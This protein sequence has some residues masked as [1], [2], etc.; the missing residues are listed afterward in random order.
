MALSAPA[1]ASTSSPWPFKAGWR[2]KVSTVAMVVLPA[3]ASFAGT[4]AAAVWAL[5]LSNAVQEW[6]LLDSAR[7]Y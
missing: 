3:A 7:F 4:A 5:S 1:Q 6:L 2:M